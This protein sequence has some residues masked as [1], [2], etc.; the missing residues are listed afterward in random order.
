MEQTG[1][2]NMKRP[3]LE[4][5]ADAKSA[6]EQL[7]EIVNKINEAES[8]EEVATAVYDSGDEVKIE[9]FNKVRFEQ[10]SE[11]ISGYSGYDAEGFLLKDGEK[12]EHITAIDTVVQDLEASPEGETLLSKMKEAVLS[13]EGEIEK[14]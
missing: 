6:E 12:T 14:E 4:A 8:M 7:E 5:A 3:D 13:A 9:T 10:L 1:F 2:E 11:T